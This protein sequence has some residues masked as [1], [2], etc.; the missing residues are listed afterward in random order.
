MNIFE[1]QMVLGKN[2]SLPEQVHLQGSALSDR[3]LLLDESAEETDR[4]V[5]AAEWHFFW[6]THECRGWSLALDQ[7]R[8]M[9]AA[10]RKAVE[11]IDRRYNAGEVVKIARKNF[12]GLHFCKIQVAARHIQQG[13]IL[14]LTE[15]VGIVAPSLVPSGNAEIKQPVQVAA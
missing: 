15:T 6:L 5:R 14:G 9:E 3:W 2:V 10:L 13:P 7:Q 4:K 8:A 1:G 11:K 12:L